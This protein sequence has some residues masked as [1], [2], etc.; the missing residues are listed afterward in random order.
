M[1]NHDLYIY[2]SIIQFH[3]RRGFYLYFILVVMFIL[4]IFI[5]ISIEF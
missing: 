3:V 4:T 2:K 5:F 1:K